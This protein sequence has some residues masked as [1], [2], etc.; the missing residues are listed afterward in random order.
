[1]ETNTPTNTVENSN[2]PLQMLAD[3]LGIEGVRKH[4][5]VNNFGYSQIERYIVTTLTNWQKE[6]D[7]VY[8]Q[9]LETTIGLWEAKYKELKESHDNLLIAVEGFYHEQI[10]NG[11]INSAINSLIS[12]AKKLK[13]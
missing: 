13:P 9:H 3:L 2:I 11:L 4:L 1:M 7:K 5:C 12:K 8:Q 10:N 6:Q